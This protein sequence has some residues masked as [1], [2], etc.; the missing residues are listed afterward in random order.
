[1]DE[2]QTAVGGCH[3]IH[4]LDPDQAKDYYRGM[5]IV[6]AFA[7]ALMPALLTASWLLT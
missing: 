7:L 5:R 1:M 3:G 6:V 4:L 2:Q